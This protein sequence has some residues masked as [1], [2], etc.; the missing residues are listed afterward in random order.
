MTTPTFPPGFPSVPE[1]KALAF[2]ALVLVDTAIGIAHTS[3]QA[4]DDDDTDTK[5]CFRGIAH[6]LRDVSHHLSLLEQYL[7]ELPAEEDRP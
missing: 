2:D 1:L 4:L 3:A 6:L 7:S 5:G